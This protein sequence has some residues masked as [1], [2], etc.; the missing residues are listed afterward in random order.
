MRTALLVLV[1]QPLAG[2][3]SQSPKP[4]LQLATVHAPAAQPATPLAAAQPRPQAPQCDTV[5]RTS[6]SQPLAALP[7]QSA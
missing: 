7:S 5:V 3:P 1:S 4:A 2:L 6:V